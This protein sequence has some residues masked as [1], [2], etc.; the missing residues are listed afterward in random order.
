MQRQDVF[1]FLNLTAPGLG[2]HGSD[3]GSQWI[4]TMESL[5]IDPFAASGGCLM[6]APDAEGKPLTRALESDEAGCWLRLLIGED[7][8]RADSSRPI[9]SHS[10]KANHVINGSK[11]WL[12]TSR[13]I[14]TW[15]PHSPIS[16]G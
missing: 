6:P 2:V 7:K 3:W 12:F 5:G 15:A 10:L 4:M 16:D 1:R 11:A 13:Q 14:V 9:S 8:N